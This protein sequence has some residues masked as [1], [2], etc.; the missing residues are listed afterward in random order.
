[1][2]NRINHNISWIVTGIAVII[3]MVIT[4]SAIPLF[5]LSIP[6]LLTIINDFME[7]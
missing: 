1:M 3:A 5:V 6:A 2:I 7:L 4:K